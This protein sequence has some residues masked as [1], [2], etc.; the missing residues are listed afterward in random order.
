MLISQKI[1]ELCDRFTAAGVPTVF[2]PLKL[3]PPGAWI[4]ARRVIGQTLAGEW[5]FEYDL[6]LV[7]PECDIPVAL[8]RLEQL[9]EK[10]LP[11]IEGDIR[12][13]DLGTSVTLPH[14]GTV[15]A[16]RFTISPP[17]Y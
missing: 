9:F 17:V 4:A 14:G 11:V 13:S 6:Y 8:T 10:C 3:N 16:F 5:L 7:V 12:D 1:V 2:D 15:P